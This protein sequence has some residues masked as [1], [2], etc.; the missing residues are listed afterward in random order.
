M[1]RTLP[2]ILFAALWVCSRYWNCDAFLVTSQVRGVSMVVAALPDVPTTTSDSPAPVN[3]KQHSCKLC[4]ASFPSRNALFRHVRAAHTDGARSEEQTIRRQSVAFRISYH[5]TQAHDGTVPEAELV[6][7]RLRGA[8]EEALRV[9]SGAKEVQVLSSAQTSVANQRHVTLSQE[10]GVAAAGDVVIANFKA[11]KVADESIQGFLERL[12]NAMRDAMKGGDETGVYVNLIAAKWLPPDKL[13]HAER[14]CTQRVY[15][16]LMPLS[17]LPDGNKLEEWLLEGGRLN[18]GHT[19]RHVHLHQSNPPCDSLKKLKESLRLA[20]SAAVPNR[21]TR[22]SALRAGEE[23]SGNARKKIRF[24]DRGSDQNV[25]MDTRRYGALAKKERK[26]WHNFA[27]P[28]LRGQASPSQEPVWRV[29][30]RS[31]MN[32]FVAMKREIDEEEEVVAVLQFRGDDFVPTQ[33]RRIVATALGVTHGWLPKDVFDI[34]QR[35]DVFLETPIAPVGR[36]YG[37]DAKFH[38]YGMDTGEALFEGENLVESQDCSHQKAI[39][40]IQTRI[41]KAKATKSSLREEEEWLSELETTIAPRICTKIAKAKN[42]GKPRDLDD[43]MSD[44]TDPPPVVYDRVLALLRS[45]VESGAWPGTSV[46]RSNVIRN[47]S[48][49]TSIQGRS[50]SF[51]IFNPKIDAICKSNN[52]PA[53]NTLFPHLVEAIF[54]LEAS[55]SQLTIQRAD[56]NGKIMAS[57]TTKT[58]RPPSFCCAVNCNAKFTPHVDSG[59]GAGQTMSMIVGLGTYT[60]GEIVVEGVSHSIAYAPLEF[61][62]WSSR[63]WTESYRGERFSLVWFSPELAKHDD[64]L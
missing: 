45:I 36:L 58:K 29:L 46:A 30:D 25:K 64:C 47:S 21:R 19:P 26:A 31:R 57:T 42:N 7:A 34:A 51:T 44:A 48:E 10:V 27:D 62:G 50:G 15:Q 56:I 40:E 11:P 43:K 32:G 63:H 61:D 53:G 3:V 18:A 6:G 28:N 37:Q 5:A 55:L 12:L 59:R 4:S 41:L 60:G 52:L 2:R 9:A 24:P 1:R 38:F 13:Y 23:G 8:L 35:A 54:E 22:R 49:Q 14:D 20:E 17:W 16:Y 39:E 33:I